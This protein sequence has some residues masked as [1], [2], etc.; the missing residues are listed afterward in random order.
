ME[1]KW[2]DG[3]KVA[4]SPFG[5]AIHCHLVQVKA[6]QVSEYS[7]QLEQRGGL[8]AIPQLEEERLVV[9]T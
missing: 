6:G 5:L 8:L 3:I 9:S 7:H 2:E 1:L 4:F